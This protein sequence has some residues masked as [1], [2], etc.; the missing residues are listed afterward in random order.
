VDPVTAFRLPPLAVDYDPCWVEVEFRGDLSDWARRT[1]RELLARPG[2]RGQGPAVRR[3]AAV[4][5]GAGAVA[6]RAQDASLALLLYP[7]LDQGVRAVARFCP[8][9][10]AGQQ[11]DEAWAGML[12][13]VSAD[14]PGQDSAEVLELVTGAGSCRRVRQLAAQESSGGG[15]PAFEQ[16]AY[17]WVF[18]A[19]GAGVI[20]ATAFTA[21]AEADLWRPEFDKLAAA[22]ELERPE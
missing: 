20:L 22:V 21:L 8:V 17:V 6:R 11:G 18:P 9:D 10:L 4:L 1:A 3:V 14:L 16:L 15:R 13:M 7:S 2:N 5:E 19:Y 12:G